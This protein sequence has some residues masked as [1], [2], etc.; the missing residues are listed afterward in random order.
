M[1]RL[2]VLEPEEDFGEAIAEVERRWVA[3]RL[4]VTRC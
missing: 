4:G 3:S 1:R 2:A